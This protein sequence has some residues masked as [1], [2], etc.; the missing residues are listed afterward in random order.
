MKDLKT[1]TVRVRMS[2]EDV[3]KLLKI[4][5]FTNLTKSEI[6]RTG[7]DIQYRGVLKA[8]ERQR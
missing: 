3:E 1:E 2:K 4:V 5:E 7:I 8:E 6:I